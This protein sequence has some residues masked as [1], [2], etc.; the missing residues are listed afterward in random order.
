[1]Y[2]SLYRRPLI[3][4][5]GVS[6]AL[7]AQPAMDQEASAA[8]ETPEREAV[9]DEIIVTAR[10]LNEVLDVNVG[11]FGAK[12]PLDVPLSVETYSAAEIANRASR[13]LLDGSR[14]TR[15]CSQRPQA[16]PRT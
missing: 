6:A 9:L 10:P 7:F 2:I 1:M 12:N 4:G 14:R 15:P 16:V 5:L 11:A 3:M 13:T 8:P